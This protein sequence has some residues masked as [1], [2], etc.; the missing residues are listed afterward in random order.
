MGTT[1]GFGDIESPIPIQEQGLI[2]AP[3]DG[4]LSRGQTLMP[5]DPLM[6]RLVSP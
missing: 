6:I 3:D 4:F 1:F 5:H 2:S